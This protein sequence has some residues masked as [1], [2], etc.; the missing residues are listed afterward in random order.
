MNFKQ[1]R[2]QK[3]DE[4]DLIAQVGLERE[5]AALRE[6]ENRYVL[7]GGEKEASLSWMD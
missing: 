1:K 3:K 6:L 7:S 4:V 5:N 2:K